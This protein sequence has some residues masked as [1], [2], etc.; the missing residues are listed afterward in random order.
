MSQESVEASN[1]ALQSK[2]MA[3]QENLRC[4]EEDMGARRAAYVTLFGGIPL[5]PPPFSKTKA[6]EEPVRQPSESS[7]PPSPSSK[8]PL[9]PALLP[10]PMPPPAGPVTDSSGAE[11]QDHQPPGPSDEELASTS[12]KVR[13]GS[14]R[15]GV[16]DIDSAGA[17]IG[18]D[19]IPSRDLRPNGTHWASEEAARARVKA[20]GRK[21]A[22]GGPGEVGGRVGVVQVKEEGEGG[23]KGLCS[24]GIRDG[25]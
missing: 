10:T 18:E 2:V 25:K 8:T 1:A 13:P 23:D 6:S 16:M 11:Q 9:P 22:R 5:N 21:G 15:G 14:A 4:L 7:M 19:S 3:Y 17:G 24:A 20:G 12:E